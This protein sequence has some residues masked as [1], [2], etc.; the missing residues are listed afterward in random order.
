MR[1]IEFAGK[2]LYLKT[3]KAQAISTKWTAESNI[4]NFFSSSLKSLNSIWTGKNRIKE[5]KAFLN[6]IKEIFSGITRA[7]PEKL[8]PVLGG[9]SCKFNEEWQTQ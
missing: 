9:F 7:S 5:S 1:K 6:E 4:Y 2:F 8:S 3:E